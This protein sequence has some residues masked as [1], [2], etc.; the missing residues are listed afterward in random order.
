M[1]KAQLDA[2][3]TAL[4]DETLS[5]TA[6]RAV[7]TGAAGAVEQPPAEYTGADLRQGVAAHALDSI[8]DNPGKFTRAAL[9]TLGA[10]AGAIAGPEPEGN[11]AVLVQQLEIGLLQLKAGD[12][13]DR[14]AAAALA[15][16]AFAALVA[17]AK[18][19]KAKAAKRAALL[20]Q[21]AALDEEDDEEPPGVVADGDEEPPGV[22]AETDE[23]PAGTIATED[24]SAPPIVASPNTREPAQLA[25]ATEDGPGLVAASVAQ[26]DTIEARAPTAPGPDGQLVGAPVQ[27]RAP[28]PVPEQVQLAAPPPPLAEGTIHAQS[29]RSV[30][31]VAVPTSVFDAEPPMIPR[32]AAEPRAGRPR[33][34]EGAAATVAVRE[35]NQSDP[36]ARAA[37]ALEG[38]DRS[39]A[40]VERWAAQLPDSDGARF[41]S[42]GTR[43]F[44][45]WAQQLREALEKNAL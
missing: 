14:V 43:N 31:Q 1:R 9:W 36:R 27:T 37:V 18:A 8:I 45:H 13:P 41:A 24:E 40:D 26:G 3:N 15:A 12:V 21:L 23:E 11:K 28:A 5:D 22:V 16:A 25:E 38:I 6:F 17:K 4:G 20:A 34:R 33:V 7:L 10:A 2:L 29:A 35:S 39:L 44:K 32:G 30:S 19:A 42:D